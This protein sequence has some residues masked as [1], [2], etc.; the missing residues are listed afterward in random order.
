MENSLD[1]PLFPD[2]PRIGLLLRLLYQLYSLDIQDALRAAGFDDIHPAAANVFTFL[3]DEGATVSHLAAQA[4][5]R[6][7]TMAQTVAQ[8]ESAGYVERRENPSDG[9]S[10]LVF[11]TAKGRQVPKVTHR[12]ADQVE[13]QWSH[14]VGSDRLDEISRSL[15][16]LLSRATASAGEGSASTTPRTRSS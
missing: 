14:L 15:S 8:L 1:A 12:A 3:G 7:Q 2:H 10:R 6:K 11:L 9:R 5:V 13:R 16:D 4:H